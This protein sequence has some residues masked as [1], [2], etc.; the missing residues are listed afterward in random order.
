MLKL[1]RK[2]PWTTLRPDGWQWL[3]VDF[4]P[5]KE[6]HPGGIY[7]TMGRG[8][9]RKCRT[10]KDANTNRFYRTTRINVHSGTTGPSR[11]P[12]LVSVEPKDKC[13][14]ERPQRTYSSLKT[15]GSL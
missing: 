10:E 12:N 4:F 7:S 1:G 13:R 8:A 6:D 14:S 5:E 9:M 2:L 3:A 15:G 11:I